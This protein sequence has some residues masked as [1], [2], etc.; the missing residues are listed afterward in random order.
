M[1]L[2]CVCDGHGQNGHQ[3]SAY[4]KSHLLENLDDSLSKCQTAPEP[5]A[6]ETLF[7]F[8]LKKTNQQLLKSDINTDLSGSTVIAVVI[9]QN[10]IYS[11]NVGDSRAILIK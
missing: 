5:E 6:I 7:Y 4:I 9:Y 2:Y 8:C 11:F 1:K 3:V 10:T